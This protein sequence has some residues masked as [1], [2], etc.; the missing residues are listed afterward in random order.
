MLLR[1]MIHDLA[2]SLDFMKSF[3]AYE[4]HLMNVA[5]PLVYGTFEELDEESVGILQLFFRANSIAVQMAVAQK[6][7]NTLL[8][9]RTE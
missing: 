4:R 8:A 7:R 9:C 2:A 3:N 6:T 1:D 5:I